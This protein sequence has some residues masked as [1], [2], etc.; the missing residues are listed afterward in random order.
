[1]GKLS[2]INTPRN[3]KRSSLNE[4]TMAAVAVNNEKSRLTCNEGDEANA[5]EARILRKERNTTSQLKQHQ[6]GD[7]QLQQHFNGAILPKRDADNNNE[8]GSQG[9]DK[10]QSQQQQKLEREQPES[11]G[12]SNSNSPTKA[13]VAVGQFLG[14]QE[15]GTT[16]GTI[17][18]ARPEAGSVV[19]RAMS[20]TRSKHSSC[21]DHTPRY[22]VRL[23]KAYIKPTKLGYIYDEDIKIWMYTVYIRL[24]ATIS[25]DSLERRM[26]QISKQLSALQARHKCKILIQTGTIMF[27]NQRVKIVNI[28]SYNKLN[29]MQCA[30]ALPAIASRDLITTHDGEKIF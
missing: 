21:G 2:S 14:Q 18:E 11:I 4:K 29:I 23:P 25:S 28:F 12:N 16:P 3:T 1:M 22:P 10:H 26:L 24:R 7:Q 5:K 30:G 17:D 27:R 13:A 6:T 20:S 19:S 9:R 8:L 15:P